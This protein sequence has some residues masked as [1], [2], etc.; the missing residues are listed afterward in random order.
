[1]KKSKDAS[2]ESAKSTQEGITDEEKR[3]V[4]MLLRILRSNDEKPKRALK[5]MMNQIIRKG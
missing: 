1:M 2:M 5:V 4:E 3:Y